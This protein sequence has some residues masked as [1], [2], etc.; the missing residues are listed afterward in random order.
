[1]K[2]IYD[3]YDHNKDNCLNKDEAK[4]FTKEIL[5]EMGYYHMSDKNLEIYINKWDVNKDGKLSRKEVEPL[6]EGVFKE[7]SSKK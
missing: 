1:M 5:E 7:V 2:K 4:L 6:L 3:K